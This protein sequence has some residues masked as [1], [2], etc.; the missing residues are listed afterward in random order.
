MLQA[1]PSLTYTQVRDRLIASAVDRGA[2]G[3][4]YDFGWGQ[5]D[6]YGAVAAVADAR[7]RAPR[8]RSRCARPDRR[9][10]G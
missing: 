3:F 5:I 2:P 9:A 7:S 10:A 6:T 4:D 1:N 8:A